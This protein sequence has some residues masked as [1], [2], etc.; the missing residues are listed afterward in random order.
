VYDT[1]VPGVG[2]TMTAEAL[3]RLLRRRLLRIDASDFEHNNPAQVSDIFKRYFHMA[4]SW[5]SL[6]LL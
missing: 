2:K 3:A 1:G 5:G 4:S 6:L